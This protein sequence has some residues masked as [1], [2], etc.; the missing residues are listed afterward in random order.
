MALILQRH[1]ARMW[2]SVLRREFPALYETIVTGGHPSPCW[3]SALRVAAR[4]D[5]AAGETESRLFVRGLAAPHVD[6][7]PELQSRYV[8]PPGEMRPL[9]PSLHW[10]TTSIA[11]NGMDMVVASSLHTPSLKIWVLDPARGTLFMK[12][13]FVLQQPQV[14]QVD[15]HRQTVVAYTRNDTILVWRV[16]ARD[17]RTPPSGNYDNQH[18]GAN[19]SQQSAPME[20]DDDSE[21]S[22]D[23]VDEAEA[24][25]AIVD[26]TTDGHHDLDGEALLDMQQQ[27]L[28]QLEF[29]EDDLREL[30]ELGLQ[31]TSLV[32][33]IKRYETRQVALLDMRGMGVAATVMQRA[34]HISVWGDYV[35]V[36]YGDREFLIWSIKQQAPFRHF[37]QDPPSPL[38]GCSYR[39][40][41]FPVGCVVWA[42]FLFTVGRTHRQVQIWNLL[43][44]ERRASQIIPPIP[45]AGL[46]VAGTAGDGTVQPQSSVGGTVITGI[47][48][49]KQHGGLIVVSAQ[50]LSANMVVPF[51][52]PFYA[53]SRPILMGGLDMQRSSIFGV[54]HPLPPF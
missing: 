44:G 24:L 16:T 49:N 15:A 48:T 45:D 20:G 40:E 27:Q 19:S 28:D 34:V 43:T 32:R 35:A 6:V 14:V 29:E 9:I 26:V 54:S 41:D 46:N 1:G 47:A 8:V 10:P 39:V 50:Q 23:E 11:T 37:R 52:M 53:T 42:D 25:L 7:T 31:G 13:I 33:P 36:G 2:S 12:P 30:S 22:F 18:S 3:R 4:L 38:K 17:F 51:V 21:E 5:A